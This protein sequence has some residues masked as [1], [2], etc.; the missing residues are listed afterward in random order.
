MITLFL[1]VLLSVVGP[2]LAVRVRLPA[3]VV[4]IVAGIGVGPV[5]LGWIQDTPPVALL[6]ELG[7]LILMFVAGME[8]DFES[9]RRAGP[10]GLLVPSLAVLLFVGVAAA[11]GIWLRLSVIELIVVS[12]SSVGMPLAVLQETGLLQRPI[13][14]HVMLTA[15]LGEFAS[16]LAITGYELFAEE[17]T[18]SHRLIK[19]L[20][21]VLLFVV[22]ATVIRWA[23]A[24]VWW[25][26]E[27]FRRLLQHHDVAELGV[28]TGLL[29]MFGFV[30]VS[31]M[32][33]V[34]AILGAF[35]GGA[36]V[37]FV[38][39]EKSTLESKISALG[40]GLFI[41][42]FF[43]VVG[44]RFN[45][46]VLSFAALKDALLFAA[47]VATVKILPTLISSPRELGLRERFAAGALLSAPL[48]LLVAIAAIGRRLG[49][50]DSAREATFLLLAILLSV[51]FPIVFRALVTS[52][53]ART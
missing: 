45:A 49:T 24:A 30:V 35:I 10:R 9:L 2:A 52:P 28:R 43:I 40:H 41:P 47:V 18:L 38:L 5:G 6:S 46:R 12:A 21:V 19:M 17:A 7:F 3:A 33:G 31:A 48:T 4:L 27:P 14:K 29:L 32:L 11:M 42:I 53:R 26:P 13:G 44:V 23:R 25:R 51:G 1:L 37:A 39:R 16:I 15:S 20:K 22:S 8:I 36:L 50:V 34:E